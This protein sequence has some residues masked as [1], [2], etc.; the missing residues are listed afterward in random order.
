MVENGRRRSADYSVE[1][2]KARWMQF[3]LDDVVPAA[4][5]WQAAP[6]R[7]ITARLTQLARTTRQKLAAKQFKLQVFMES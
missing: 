6:R 5:A 1:S 2:T 3:L 4:I 7:S